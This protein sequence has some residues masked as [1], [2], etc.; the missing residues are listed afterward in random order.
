MSEQLERMLPPREVAR[1]ASVTLGTVYLWVKQ[2]RIKAFRVG[3][4]RTIRIPQ[5]AFEAFV[6][7]RPASRPAS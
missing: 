7:S 1:L 2:G 3:D 6:A 5:S 4:G